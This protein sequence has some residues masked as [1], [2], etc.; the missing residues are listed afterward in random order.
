MS[1]VHSIGDGDKVT[2]GGED[3]AVD[4]ATGREVV[5]GAEDKGG[6]GQTGIVH[7][8]SDALPLTEG[9]CEDPC[10]GGERWW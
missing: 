2:R 4:G 9:V 5:N 1:S 6:G 7:L 10:L 8:Q 3:D